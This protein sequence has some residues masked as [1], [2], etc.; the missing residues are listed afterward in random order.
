PRRSTSAPTSRPQSMRVP[1][2]RRS[3]LQQ[4]FGLTPAHDDE[5]ARAR[6]RV[7]TQSSTEVAQ[8]LGALQLGAEPSGHLED[9]ADVSGE[10]EERAARPS[11]AEIRQQTLDALNGTARVVPDKPS[12]PRA[13][14]RWSHRESS[15]P[16][17]MRL[18]PPPPMGIA[19][20]G[21]LPSSSAQP[22][23][24]PM[25]SE[26]D[27]ANGKRWAPAFWAPPPVLSP[28]HTWSPRDSAD[29]FESVVSSDAPRGSLSSGRRRGGSPW[30][31]VRAS[32]SRTFSPAHSRPGTPPPPSSA[33]S[34]GF[35]DDESVP[36]ADE[37]A[38][39]ARRSLS[40]RMSRAAFR[41]AEPLPESDDALEPDRADE[42]LSARNSPLAHVAES[43]AQPKR[44][45]LLWQFG[46]K[47]SN[48]LHPF[49]SDC[50]SVASDDSLPKLPLPLIMP[51]RPKKWWWTSVLGQ[52]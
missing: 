17:I 45:S 52:V 31:M 14:S 36:D 23:A 34:L 44:K 3:W 37:L 10:D 4:V 40:L 43:A 25:K 13:G 22:E 49:R 20:R 46:S 32:E 11:V 21:S 16:T 15:A 24:E 30:E 42:R 33:R 29:S 27:S 28:A 12:E 48:D 35:F 1:S 8:L 7:M 39:A 5:G 18:N 26:G 2:R 41:Q 47:P 19:R 9:V 51:K 6:R 50:A 38:M